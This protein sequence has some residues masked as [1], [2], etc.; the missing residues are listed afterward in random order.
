M[1]KATKLLQ[2]Q[3]RVSPDE[4]AA[5]QR[6]A[7]HAGMGMSEWILSH[8]LSTGAQRFHQLLGQLKRDKDKRYL[9]SE[10]HDLFHTATRKEFE[11]MVANPPGVRLLPYWEN[12]VAA[13]IEYT[14]NQ[15][16]TSPPAWVR[17][18]KPLSQPVFG[19]DLMSLRL[20]L[21]THSPPP[22]RYRNI[23]IDSTVGKCV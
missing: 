11:Q 14:A 23:F 22:F 6:A 8:I 5:I 16:G 17:E 7:K 3:I 15:K 4:K 1:K 2:L 21:L 10:L 20:Y 9:L 18:I 13:M 19:T 12:Y